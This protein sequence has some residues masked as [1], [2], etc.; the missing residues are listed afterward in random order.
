MRAAG[1]F[2]VSAADQPA[3]AGLRGLAKA[4]LGTDIV[5]ASLQAATQR[6][7]E[8]FDAIVVDELLATPYL[9]SNQ[10]GP[11]YFLAARC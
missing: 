4:R 11:V 5:N 10:N 9:P 8:G 2:L 7:K 3:V 6:R 1:D